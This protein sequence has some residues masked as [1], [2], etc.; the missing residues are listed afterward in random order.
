M[1]EDSVLGR[2]G[3]AGSGDPPGLLAGTGELEDEI[4]L[5]GSRDQDP[6]PVNSTRDPNFPDGPL[7]KP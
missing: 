7:M 4:C 6:D 2:V 5:D 1:P 3:R